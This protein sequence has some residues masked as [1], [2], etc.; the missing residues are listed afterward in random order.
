MNSTFLLFLSIFA[1]FNVATCFKAESTLNYRQSVF[2]INWITHQTKWPVNLEK[3]HTDMVSPDYDWFKFDNQAFVTQLPNYKPNYFVSKENKKSELSIFSYDTKT[4]EPLTTYEPMQ[5]SKFKKEPVTD[6]VLEYFQLVFLKSHRIRIDRDEAN[7]G[8]NVTCIADFLV[9][10]KTMEINPDLVE[11][12]KNLA[13]FRVD[14]EEPTQGDYIQFKKRIH[15]RNMMQD[16]LYAKIHNANKLDTSDL[17]SKTKRFRRSNWSTDQFN[18]V[19]MNIRLSFGPI[20]VPQPINER[21][22]SCSLDLVNLETV[23]LDYQN[24]VFK[25]LSKND[26][27]LD[28]NADDMVPS[29][30]TNMIESIETVPTPL[31]KTTTME[32][33][34]TKSFMKMSDNELNN[35]FK[36]EEVLERIEQDVIKKSG[37]KSFEKVADKLEELVKSELI[38]KKHERR[39]FEMDNSLLTFIDEPVKLNFN[40][41]TKSGIN[42]SVLMITALISISQFY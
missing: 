25:F 9:D 42:Y 7:T 3:H 33:T 26:I 6:Q 19:I 2:H 40:S 11:E 38:E 5:M 16:K 27:G 22:I 13:L 4:H 37:V 35:I 36:A 23:Q 14:L 15:R 1:I 24:K 32:T 28:K 8:A 21:L 18:K 31:S 20:Y 29:I 41:A 34:T 39:F 12:M 30:S 10:Q 17:S